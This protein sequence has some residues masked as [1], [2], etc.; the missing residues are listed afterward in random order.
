LLKIEQSPNPILLFQHIQIPKNYGLCQEL[1]AKVFLHYYSNNNQLD[2]L[3]FILCIQ[4]D[5][6]ID[7]NLEDQ[8][9]E[10]VSKL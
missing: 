6:A 10:L 5:T 1:I 9:N 4:I 8:T 7:E 3:F 2:K